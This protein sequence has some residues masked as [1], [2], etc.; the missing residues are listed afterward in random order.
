M[1][2]VLTAVVG[3]PPLIFLAYLGGW[4]LA[5]FAV[6]LG[7][8]LL[9]E[10]VAL[11]ARKNWTVFG[12]TAALGISL[13]AVSEPV[14]DTVP[15]RY[16]LLAIGLAL[17]LQTFTDGLAG[18]NWITA[19]RRGALTAVMIA[20]IGLPLGLFVHIRG[21][22]GGFQLALLGFLLTWATDTLAYYTGKTLGGPRLAPAVSPGK[23]VSGALGGLAG[24]TA[25]ALIMRGW[26]PY[27]TSEL[28]I[29]G[30]VAASAA[31]A[32]DLTE[33]AIK[34]FTGVKD[35]GSILPGHGGF[36]DRFDSFLFVV[37][38]LYLFITLTG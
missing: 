6:A 27:A 20:Y 17:A 25:A 26:L 29:L 7:L 14:S 4:L 15:F 16:L 3:I 28:V 23:T 8:T 30:L 31:Q 32:G 2:R 19:F 21:F 38:I 18:G 37:P 9:R 13:A 12:Q 24:G 36:L 33:S 10:L 1:K 11:L 35:A 22:S 34:R 5:L